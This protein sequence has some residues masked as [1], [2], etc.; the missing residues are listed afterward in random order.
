MS[1]SRSDIPYLTHVWNPVV[2]CNQGCGYCWCGPLL[3]RIG[4]SI[5][6]ELCIEN[7]PHVH[8]ERLDVPGGKPK[9]I[10]VGFMTDLFGARADTPHF[11]VPLFQVA[12]WPLQ[13]WHS[14]AWVLQ[15]IMKRMRTHPEHTFVTPTK[16][17]NLIPD[18]LDPPDNWWLLATCTNQGDIEGNL[19]AALRLWTPGRIVF[20]LEPLVEGVELPGDI[21][22]SN[23]VAGVVLGGMSQQGASHEP[24]PMHPDWVRSVRDQCAE[25][26][27]PFYFKQWSGRNP[28]DCPE[29]DG[30]RHTALPWVGET[31]VTEEHE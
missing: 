30:R 29:L 6:C 1:I 18:D 17:A 10:G 24:V 7:I 20:N 23:T 28:E 22:G 31:G 2:G 15:E 19:S 14:R 13:G 9:V 5:G 25:A 27:V 3:K 4:A 8:L 26:G 12:C 16:F 11:G 21:V